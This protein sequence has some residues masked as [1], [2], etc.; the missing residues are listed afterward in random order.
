MYWAW[1]LIPEVAVTLG[2]AKHRSGGGR[3]DGCSWEKESAGI[4]L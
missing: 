1:F 2:A 4:H 3:G